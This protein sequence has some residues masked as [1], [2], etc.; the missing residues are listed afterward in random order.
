[1]FWNFNCPLVNIEKAQRSISLFNTYW[2]ENN[3]VHGERTSLIL[4][5]PCLSAQN[6]RA[7]I[8]LRCWYSVLRLSLSYWHSV[9]SFTKYL[10]R[11]KKLPFYYKK[12]KNNVWPIQ[13]VWF[14]ENWYEE[15]LRQLR[16]GL[17]KCYVVAFH[18][19]SAVAVATVTPHTLNFIKKV[20]STFGIGIGISKST[21]YIRLFNEIWIVY[22]LVLPDNCGFRNV[23]FPKIYY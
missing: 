1:M 17:A 13:M 20:V 12:N 5:A 6:I 15:V 18:H 14:R 8:L 10:M 7:R 16:A 11:S 3:A 2:L 21:S 4:S 22:I 9:T 19:R 23:R